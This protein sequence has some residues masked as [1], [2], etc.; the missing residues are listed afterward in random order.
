MQVNL[1]TALEV[2]VGLLAVSAFIAFV[3]LVAW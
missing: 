1:S 3:A 2:F